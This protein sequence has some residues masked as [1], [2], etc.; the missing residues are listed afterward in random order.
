MIMTKGDWCNETARVHYTP[1]HSGDGYSFGGATIVAIG[2]FAI[3]I[4]EHPQSQ[5]LGKE[6]VERWNANANAA[7]ARDVTLHLAACL[8]GAISLLERTDKKS[9]PSDKMFDQMLDD[10]RGA[11]A[12]FRA[13][14]AA[15]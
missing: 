6:I 5:H 12:R 10:Y 13:A 1:V 4:G 3:P 8:A 11:L 7:T 2:P 14:E 9:A 15:K